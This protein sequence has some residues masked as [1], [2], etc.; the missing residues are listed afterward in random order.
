MSC[1][2]LKALVAVALGNHFNVESLMIKRIKMEKKEKEN[3][4]NTDKKVRECLG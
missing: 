3:P 4:E 1:K 2:I